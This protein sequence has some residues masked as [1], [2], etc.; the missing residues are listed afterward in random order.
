MRKMKK[1]IFAIITVFSFVF[2]LGS[3][4]AADCEMIGI[5]ELLIRN[6]IGL[7]IFGGGVIGIS[8]Y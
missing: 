5:K 3:I 7:F 1:I 2:L 6:I 4:G 8:L